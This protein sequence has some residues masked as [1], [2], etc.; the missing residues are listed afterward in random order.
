MKA[1]NDSDRKKLKEK[2]ENAEKREQEHRKEV[3]GFHLQSTIRKF[4][5]RENV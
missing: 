4:L 5:D 3:K 1:V 2:K